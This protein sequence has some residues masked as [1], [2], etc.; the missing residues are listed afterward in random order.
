MSDFNT[1]SRDLAIYSD[2]NGK[3]EAELAQ[4][5]SLSV[6]AI[7]TIVCDLACDESVIASIETAQL[8]VSTRSEF[9]GFRHRVVDRLSGVEMEWFTPF[10]DWW[11]KGVDA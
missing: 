2:F 11:T 6:D 7:R 10:P 1:R 4:K 8:I 5:Y 9:N 3:N